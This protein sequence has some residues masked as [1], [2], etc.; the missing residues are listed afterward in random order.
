MP[1]NFVNQLY[2]QHL[3]PMTSPK[4]PSEGIRTPSSSIRNNA[5]GSSAMV[6]RYGSRIPTVDLQ[7]IQRSNEQVAANI[8]SLAEEMKLMGDSYKRTMTTDL[9]WRNELW[10]KNRLV[11]IGER[12]MVSHFNIAVLDS[13]GLKLALFDLQLGD[14]SAKFIHT[15]L[16][17]AFKYTVEPKLYEDELY[18]D[19]ELMEGQILPFDISSQS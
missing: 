9:V 6:L 5:P 18:F 3:N 16:K 19:I 11:E 10:I 2:S 12:I 15:L 7:L 4:S 1:S 17:W 14:T 13:D 8:L